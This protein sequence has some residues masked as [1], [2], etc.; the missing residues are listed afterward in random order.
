MVGEGEAAA[1]R[2]RMG[3]LYYLTPWRRETARRQLKILAALEHDMELQD[4]KLQV[5]SHHGSSDTSHHSSD[6]V[7]EYIAH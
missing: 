2:R 5:A 7:Y 3:L 4:D 6:Y 1:V